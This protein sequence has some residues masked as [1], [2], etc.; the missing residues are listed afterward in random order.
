[1]SHEAKFLHKLFSLPNLDRLLIWNL[2]AIFFVQLMNSMVMNT[3]KAKLI[4]LI[5]HLY[6]C[7]DLS[8]FK[9]ILGLNTYTYIHE[10][11]KNT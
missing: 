8:P 7:M 6:I 9:W 4:H 1:M 5:H 3:H 11:F 10:L 2:E